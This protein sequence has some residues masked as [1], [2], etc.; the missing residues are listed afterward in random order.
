MLRR[1]KIIALAAMCLLYF[2]SYFQRLALPGTLFDELQT[3]FAATATAITV[4][5]AVFMYIYGAMQ[6]FTGLLAD[7]YGGARVLLTGGALLAVS[8]VV[9]PLMH[10]L[11]C[12]YAVRALTGLGASLIFISL[13]K[14]LDG[15]FPAR[16]FA[17]ILCLCL[18]VGYAG[19]LAGTLP[20]A[21]LAGRWGWRSA[22]FGAGLLSGLAW[23]LALAVLRGRRAPAPS[24]RQ[25]TL[26][27]RVKIILSNPDTWPV[28]GCGMVNFGVYFLW[29]AV[30]GK[31]M[32]T[33]AGGLTPDRA[34]SVSFWMMLVCML[35]TSLSGFV[36]RLL[37]NRRRPVIFGCAGL[38]MLALAVMA[39][40]LWR[41]YS[42]RWLAACLLLLGLASSASPI[43]CAVIKEVNPPESAGASVGLVNGACYMAIALLSHLAGLVLD[44]FGGVQRAGAVVVYPRAAYLTVM[45]G[46]LVL[47][48]WSCRMAWKVRESH[49]ACVYGRPPG[50]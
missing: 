23:L 49:G 15:M 22:M 39:A 7:R 13:V 32:L 1:H 36:S 44:A 42:P 40:A 21:R 29:Q 20:L 17:M 26:W 2:F 43:I 28:M 10:S 30:L 45:A 9:F 5:G 4:L 12:L 46:C 11:P 31:K 48:A 34:A 24:A 47:A 33:D 25:A 19:G 41:G 37:Q 3:D 38:T 16:H 18:F 27:Q 14:E 6:F 8:S 50:V 35:A